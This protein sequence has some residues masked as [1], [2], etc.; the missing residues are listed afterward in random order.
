MNIAWRVLIGIAASAIAF[1]AVAGPANAQPASS[2]SVVDD[3]TQQKVE[4]ASMV[5]QM[6]V[7][8][9]AASELN[10]N[11][12]ALAADQKSELLATLNSDKPY[13]VLEIGPA[14]TSTTVDGL[15]ASPAS[16]VARAAEYDVTSNFSYPTYLLGVNTGSWNIRYRYVTG[17]GIVLRDTSCE[18]W[19]SGFQ[20]FWNFDISTNKWV[21][22]GL[23]T[24]I[25]VFRGS[26]VFKGTGFTMNKEMGMTVNGPG[27]L[28]TWLNN[29]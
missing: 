17:S 22:N 27:I 7:S 10:A 26:I 20:G 2:A 8:P 13:E 6:G 4:F 9:L 29:I 3:A 21:A 25:A 28:R 5:S 23:G 19:Y 14:Q 24:C 15:S 16:R 18:G 1:S 11:F 12:S